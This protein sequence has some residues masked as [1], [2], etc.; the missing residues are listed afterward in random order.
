MELTNN[1]IK[2]LSDYGGII[3]ILWGNN[4]KEKAKLIH[5]DQEKNYILTA[6]HPS[7]LSANRGGFFGCNNFTDCNK[8]LEKLGKNPI[9]WNSINII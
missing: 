2:Y 5:N 4:A 9:D 7:P 3:F 6:T 1:L 8:I